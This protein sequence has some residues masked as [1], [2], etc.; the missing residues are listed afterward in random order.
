MYFTYSKFPGIF[1]SKRFRLLSGN[2]RQQK[3]LI[4]LEEAV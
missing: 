4:K 2:K 1:N 3:N